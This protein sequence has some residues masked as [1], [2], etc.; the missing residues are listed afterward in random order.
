MCFST[1]A[2]FV[3]GLSLSAVGVVSLRRAEEP[4]RFPFASIPLVFGVQQLIE[5]VVWLS[6]THPDYATYRWA[7]SC[8]YL[9]FAQAIWPICVPFS[10]MLMEEDRQRKRILL[11][12]TIMGSLVAIFLLYYIFL[13][14]STGEVRDHHIHYGLKTPSLLQVFPGVLYLLA[15]VIPPFI[16]SVKR[17][18]WLGWSS[19]LSLLVSVFYF[20]QS[21]VSVWCFFAAIIS[22]VVV[23]VLNGSDNTVK[24]IIR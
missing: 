19:L 6:L 24:V 15:T 10:I 11:F 3:V 14:H 12:L 21:F 20:E 1:T 7:S 17:M 2:S 16:S 23:W 4:R 18:S 8:V 5:G 9:I 22:V 13:N